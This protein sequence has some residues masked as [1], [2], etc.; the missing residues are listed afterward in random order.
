[1]DLAAR[2]LAD[3]PLLARGE[4]ELDENLAGFFGHVTLRFH[5]ALYE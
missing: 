3:L 2:S 5:G 1:V 4:G